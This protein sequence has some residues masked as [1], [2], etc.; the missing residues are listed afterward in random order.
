[1]ALSKALLVGALAMDVH[2]QSPHTPK[3]IEIDGGSRVIFRLIS[4]K[5]GLRHILGGDLF[6][7]RQTLSTLQPHE[8][9]APSMRHWAG[10]R[11]ESKRQRWRLWAAEKE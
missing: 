9:N 6:I 3:G 8:T 5:A 7:K 2:F 1:M 10:T 4:E 11:S